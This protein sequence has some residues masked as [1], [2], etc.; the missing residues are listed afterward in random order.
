MLKKFLSF[1]IAYELP[2]PFQSA[3][4]LQIASKCYFNSLLTTWLLKVYFYSY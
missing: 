4:L 3:Y 2:K 1:V